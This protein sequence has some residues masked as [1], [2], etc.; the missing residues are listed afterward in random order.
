MAEPFL[1]ILFKVI[2]L[3]L[4]ENIAYD[5]T[6]ENWQALQVACDRGN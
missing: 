5:S 4:I 2:W 1:L 3:D 6:K